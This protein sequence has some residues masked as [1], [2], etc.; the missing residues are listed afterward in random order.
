MNVYFGKIT[1]LQVSELWEGINNDTKDDVKENCGEDNEEG[2]LKD[3][4]ISE[5]YEAIVILMQYHTLKMWEQV[6]LKALNG[7]QWEVANPLTLKLWRQ[8]DSSC[9]G[10]TGG[11]KNT[12]AP[13]SKTNS[14]SAAVSLFPLNLYM[15]QHKMKQRYYRN[16]KMQWESPMVPLIETIFLQILI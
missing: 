2:H 6:A 7:I 10:T 16:W 13:S 1:Y 8:L 3:D 4:K 11:L 12:F 9:K 15:V 14:S 5:S